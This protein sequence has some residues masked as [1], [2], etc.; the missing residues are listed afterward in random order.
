M[1]AA[2]LPRPRISVVV[3]THDTCALTLA[4]LES[5]EAAGTAGVETILVDDA[6]SDGTAE[7]VGARFPALRVLRNARPL[8]FTASANRGLGAAEG[9][10]LLLL[11]SDTA[12]GTGAWEVLEAAF[13]QHGSLGV[14]G[15]ALSFPDGTPQWSGGPFPSLPWLFVLGSGMAP[16]LA[17]IP[18][19]RVVRPVSGVEGGPVDWVT[20][21][22]MAFRRE[23]WETLGPFHEGFRFYGQDLDFCAR[24][25]QAGWEVSV[26]AGFRVEHH[27]GATIGRKVDAAG[28]QSPERLWRDLLLWAWKHRGR[29]WA[30]RAASV[31]RAG[32]GLRLAS[33][34]L[35]GLFLA[36]QTRSSWRRDSLAYRRALAGVRDEILDLSTRNGESRP[37]TYDRGT[38][39]ADR[40]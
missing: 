13:R 29:R 39:D 4:C 7:A 38:P 8:G 35:L 40:P 21:A 30:K 37:R 11:N 18:G 34:F 12:V 16:Y 2:G 3:P 31:L 9:E 14:V 1:P 5:V 26:V 36:G 28:R 10:I 27:Q 20:G 22:A 24:V 25:R 6:S 17:R 33:R 19:V 15:A 23:I 32:G